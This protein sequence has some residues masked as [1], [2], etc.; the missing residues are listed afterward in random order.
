MDNIWDGNPSKTEVIGRCCANEKPVEDAEWTQSNAK[1]L[2]HCNNLEHKMYVSYFS[3]NW[4]FC[5]ISLL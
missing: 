1:R 4:L 5:P 2:F 3:I